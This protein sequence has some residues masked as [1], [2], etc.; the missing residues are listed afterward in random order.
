[1]VAVHLSGVYWRPCRFVGSVCTHS[2][3]SSA[4][5]EN[6]GL[7]GTVI[8]VAII[9]FTVTEKLC[10][11]CHGGI[12]CVCVCVCVV[13]PS[14]C[15]QQSQFLR[16]NRDQPPGDAEL[17]VTRLF[18]H[19]TKA[20][21][22]RVELCCSISCC[23]DCEHIHWDGTMHIRLKDLWHSAYDFGMK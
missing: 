9:S 22:K 13:A 20:P 23:S 5:S 2:V 14:C 21:H 6:L 16:R 3:S 4:R 7:L 12:R 15:N 1:M 10:H 17:H 18:L 8:V 19:C 11:C